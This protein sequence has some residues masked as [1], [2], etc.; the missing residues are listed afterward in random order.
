MPGGDTVAQWPWH[1]TQEDTQ[2]CLRS[3][4]DT[5][6]VRRLAANHRN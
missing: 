1:N 5:T 6:G 2:A 4:P 3:H